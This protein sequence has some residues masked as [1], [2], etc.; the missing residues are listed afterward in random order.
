MVNSALT[1]PSGRL[2]PAGDSDSLDKQHYEH[3]DH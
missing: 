3:F 1:N 2:L